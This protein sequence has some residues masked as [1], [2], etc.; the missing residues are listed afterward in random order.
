MGLG[1][2][3]DHMIW[4]ARFTRDNQKMLFLKGPSY[5]WCEHQ[6]TSRLFFGGFL[7]GNPSDHTMLLVILNGESND[8]LWGYLN[9]LLNTSE[10]PRLIRCLA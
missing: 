6:G 2:I 10:R 8:Y 4:G 3:T 7:Q 1:N 5:F 9:F